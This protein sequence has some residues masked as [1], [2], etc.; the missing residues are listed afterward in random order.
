MAGM[1]TYS[2]L[3]LA[4]AIVFLPASPGAV[5]GMDRMAGRLCGTTGH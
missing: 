3:L 4:R 2:P 1:K 5:G